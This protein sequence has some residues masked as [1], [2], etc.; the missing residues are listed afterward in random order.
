MGFAETQGALA[1]CSHAPPVSPAGR[2]PAQAEAGDADDDT[3]CEVA[4]G[5]AAPVDGDWTRWRGCCSG[6][7]LGANVDAE[8]VHVLL[9]KLKAVSGCPQPSV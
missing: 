1:S 5:C 2:R 6:W 4:G 7:R 3:L 8:V 9:G